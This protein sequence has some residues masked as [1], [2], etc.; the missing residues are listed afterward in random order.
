MRSK[1]QSFSRP[2]RPTLSR[3][4]SASRYDSVGGAG[5]GGSP[6][7]RGD[8]ASLLAAAEG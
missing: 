4:V 8:K 3:S 5:G 2:R 1:H 6:L 7:A